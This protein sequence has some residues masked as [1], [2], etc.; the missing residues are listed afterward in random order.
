MFSPPCPQE[1]LLQWL[2]VEDTS[3]CY[4]IMQIKPSKVRSLVYQ[5]G[6]GL[7]ICWGVACLGETW[8]GVRVGQQQRLG[9][10][11]DGKGGETLIGQPTVSSCMAS[12]QAT[13][14]WWREGH[15]TDQRRVEDR[16]DMF[17]T[18]LLGFC[19]GCVCAHLDYIHKSKA[20]GGLFSATG[21]KGIFVG[22]MK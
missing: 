20:A 10:L 19:V 16:T 5:K 18:R 15:T 21:T 17:P 7:W 22:W 6:A 9:E 11:H 8:A 14:C 4:Y 12:H 1:V 2:S 3:L 13:I